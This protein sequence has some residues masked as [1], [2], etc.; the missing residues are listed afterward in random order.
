MNSFVKIGTRDSKLALVQANCVKK[1]LAKNNIK[2]KIIKIKSQGDLN[3]STPLYEFGI[4]GIFTKTLDIALLNGEIDLA[5]HSYKDVPTVPAKGIKI[6]CVLKR[7]DA[8]DIIMLSKK[9]IDFSKKLIIATSSIRRKC[10]W[11]FKYPHHKIIPIRGNVDTRIKKLS[12]GKFDGA[13]FALAGIKR[14]NLEIDNILE[15]NWMIPSAAQ[16]TIAVASKEENNYLDNIL[17]KINCKETFHAVN[18]ER[19]FIRL[20][21]GGCSKPIAA[22][23]FYEKNKLIL[24]T[25]ICSIDG[26]RSIEDRS[27]YDKNDNQAGSKSFKKIKKLGGIKIL[28]WDENDCIN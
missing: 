20:T 4:T 27:I 3:L 25:N 24:E 12:Q 7:E 21:S 17:N 14:L 6:D 5:V 9:G 13:I 18:Q 23:A 26:K 1:A 11:L 22:H 8:S 19:E 2:A 15:L 10:Q 28:D 16:G